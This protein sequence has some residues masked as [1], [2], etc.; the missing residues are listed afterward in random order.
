MMYAVNSDELLS[1]ML[2][3]QLIFVHK[4]F[5]KYGMSYFSISLNFIKFYIFFPHE[6]YMHTGCLLSVVHKVVPKPLFM[7]HIFPIIK[8]VLNEVKK[9]VK[10]LCQ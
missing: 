5:Y 4:L 6:R 7:A 8:K 10:N 1:V 2:I 3:I 9:Y